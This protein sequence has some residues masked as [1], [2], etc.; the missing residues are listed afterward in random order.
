MI[1]A[2]MRLKTLERKV[3]A[4]LADAGNIARFPPLMIWTLDPLDNGCMGDRFSRSLPI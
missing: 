3:S 4:E 1:S 2:F